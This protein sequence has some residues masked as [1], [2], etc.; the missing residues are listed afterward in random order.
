[1]ARAI[2]GE[3]RVRKNEAIDRVIRRLKK[4]TGGVPGRG[5]GKHFHR[6]SKGPYGEG[7]DKRKQGRHRNRRRKSKAERERIE[8]Q[9]GQA[10]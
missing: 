1:M 2:I 7:W 8:E 6:L 4:E 10:S 9:R 3:V 5:Q